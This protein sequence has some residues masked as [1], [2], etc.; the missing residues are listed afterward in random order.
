MPNNTT[1]VS[2]RYGWT[3]FQDNEE[4]YSGYDVASLGFPASYVNSMTYQKFPAATL[5]G[6]T[7]PTGFF[8]NRAIQ[9]NLYKSWAANGSV[10][11]LMGRQTIKFGAD[12][13]QIGVD[14]TGQDQSSGNF[15]FAK[16]WTQQNP[17]V[18]NSSQGSAFGTFL[19]GIGT[20][21]TPVVTPLEFFV[22]YGG[23]ICRTTSG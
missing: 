3:Y 8:G 13:R 12:Y 4:P 14:V 5:E 19:L 15:N 21:A 20:G 23:C 6:Y 10:S 11:K 17:L 1:V 9:H 18:A 22:R 7:N 16:T 2:L